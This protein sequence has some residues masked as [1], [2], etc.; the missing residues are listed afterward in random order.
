DAA[1]NLWIVGKTNSRTGFAT[2][3]GLYTTFTSSTVY[4]GSVFIVK[5]NPADGYPIWGSYYGGLST[6][7]K[8]I[9]CDPW[10]N[11]Y[12]AY[13]TNADGWATP[14]SHQDTFL[15][16]ATIMASVVKFE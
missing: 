12:L 4:E 16:D 9:A 8:D 13:T 3:N 5:L 15:Q 10:G 14:G 7:E 11:L 2:S 1:G 6:G